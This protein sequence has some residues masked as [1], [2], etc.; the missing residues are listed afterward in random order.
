MHDGVAAQEQEAT[1]C[2]AACMVNLAQLE[3]KAQRYTECFTWCDRALKC[4]PHLCTA[5]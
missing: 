3:F 4:G 1:A 5:L 2:K